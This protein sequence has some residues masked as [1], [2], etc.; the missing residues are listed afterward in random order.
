MADTYMKKMQVKAMVYDSPHS[1]QNGCHQEHKHQ[2]M[3]V[4]MWGERNPHTLLVG[5]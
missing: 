3:L 4:K 2:Q 1:I 5:M